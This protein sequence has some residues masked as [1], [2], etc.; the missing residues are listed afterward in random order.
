MT[1]TS[2]TSS[3]NAMTTRN[4]RPVRKVFTT[5]AGGVSRTPYTS[6]NLAMHVGDRPTDV[7][8]NRARLADVLGLPLNRFVWME[9]VHSTNV[10]VVDGPQ[11]EP[12]EV[13]DALVTTQRE[14]ALA[15]LV[16]DCVPVLLSDTEAGVIAAVHAG[17]LGARNGI[18][19]KTIDVMMD[20]GAKPA[21]IHVL[22]GPAASGWRYE[23]PEHMANDVEAR[24]PGSKTKTWKG[25]SGLDIRKGLVR[26][27]LSRG[28]RAIDAD[29]RCTIEDENF[30]SYRR[31]A[32]TG[33]QA[34]IVWLP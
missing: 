29:P 10:T 27:L 34:G 4:D 32:V 9:Q 1:S 28:V 7:A 21:N 15:V 14:L 5:N 11:A 25:T 13:T 19:N 17:R 26:Q 2:L 24:L 31:Q 8:A 12:V 22:L 33:R 30:Y 6:F 20:L 16:A 3:A 23:V 18:V